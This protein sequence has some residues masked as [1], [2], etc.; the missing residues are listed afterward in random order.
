M[1]YKELTELCRSKNILIQDLCEYMDMTRPGLTKA[2]DN[3]TLGIRKIKLLCEYLRIS[4]ALLFDAGSFGAIHKPN[5]THAENN[6]ALKKEIE[7]LKN[8]LRDKEEIIN[9]LREK[10]SGYRIASEGAAKYELE[11]KTK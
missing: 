11:K 2:M 6:D 1:D 5:V 3:E 7:Y 8:A 10:D 9:L 4:P